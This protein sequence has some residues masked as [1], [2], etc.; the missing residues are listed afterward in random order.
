ML[1]IIGSPLYLAPEIYLGGGYDERIDLWSLGVT[2]YKLI[3]G[4]TPFESEYHSDT[5]ANIIKGQ[6]KFEF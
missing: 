2:I 6:A 3:A 4:F 1:T 5:I